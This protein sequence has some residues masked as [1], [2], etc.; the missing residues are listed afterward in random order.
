MLFNATPIASW[1]QPTQS[2]IANDHDESN[3]CNN[4]CDSIVNSELFVILVPICGL[5]CVIVCCIAA[6]KFAQL[7]DIKKLEAGETTRKG[8][9]RH[10]DN[11][12]ESS[13]ENPTSLFTDKELYGQEEHTSNI[14]IR[15]TP[16]ATN[17]GKFNYKS[18]KNTPNRNRNRNNATDIND[19]IEK[20]NNIN[21]TNTKNNTSTNDNIT[22][23]IQ[24]E[25]I[26]TSNDIKNENVMKTIVNDSDDNG[27]H[28]NDNNDNNNNNNDN[29]RKGE[30]EREP[31]TNS[32]NTI[33]MTYINKHKHP[34]P[35]P[36]RPPPKFKRPH[37]TPSN[38]NR[39]RNGNRNPPPV[40]TRGDIQKNKTR[41]LPAIPK[42]TGVSPK[43][44]KSRGTPPRAP[45]RPVRPRFPMKNSNSK[46]GDQS[47]ISRTYGSESA[48]LIAVPSLPETVS[49]KNIQSTDSRYSTSFE[50]MYETIKPN[51][52][53]EN[54]GSVSM[55]V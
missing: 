31:L 5:L 2:P 34:S 24:F 49:L 1:N 36:K 51:S 14:K 33:A 22:E 41:K 30:T 52:D 13:E 19:K 45:R 21:S 38:I 35:P 6:Y 3:C 12:S 46:D 50:K 39:N 11:H 23:T 17:H 16:Q 25:T 18:C 54:N 43:S 29:N 47:A 20:Q 4:K 42:R 37:N 53:H 10:Q 40:R 8:G 9:N 44:V 15:L 7:Y 26:T 48:Q 55:Q 27:S 28:N 32:N